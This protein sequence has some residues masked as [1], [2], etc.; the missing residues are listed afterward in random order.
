MP[1]VSDPFEELCG[2][3]RHF[4]GHGEVILYYRIAGAGAEPVAGLYFGLSGFSGRSMGFTG[5]TGF[6]LSIQAVYAKSRRK[7]APEAMRLQTSSRAS[8]SSFFCKAS[9]RSS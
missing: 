4:P 9:R 1:A 2:S 5:G 6:A 3:Y 8:W 7:A